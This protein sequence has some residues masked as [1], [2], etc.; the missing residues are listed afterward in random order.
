M[1]KFVKEKSNF[2]KR[3]V[4]TTMFAT[5]LLVAVTMILSSGLTAAVGVGRGGMNVTQQ[6]QGATTP[7]KKVTLQVATPVSVAFNKNMGTSQQSPLGRAEVLLK[8]HHGY[9][10]NAVGFNGAMTWEGAMRLTPVELS[11]YG[12]WNIMSINYYYYDAVSINGKVKIYH[13][14]S[15]TAPGALWESVNFTQSTPGLKTTILPTPIP[16][17]GT[18]DIWVS[19]EWQQLAAGFPFGVDSGPAIDGKGDWI[20]YSGVWSEMQTIPLDFNWVLEALA[21]GALAPNDVGVTSITAPASGTATS[22]IIP[23]ATVKNFGSLNQTNVPV[24]MNITAYGNPISYFSDG[25]ESYTLGSYGFPAGWTNTSINPTGDW[26]MYA[27]AQTYSASTYPRVQEALSDGNAQ[28][29]QLISP[30]IDCSA[31]TAVIKLQFTKYFYASPAA[32]ATFTVYGSDDGGATWAYTLATYTTTSTTA[33]NISIAWAAG[34]NDVRFKFRFQSPADTSLLSYLYFDNLWV[35]QFLGNWGPNGNNPPVGW[36][37][38]R[39]DTT[40]WDYGHWH[41][42]AYT[43]YDCYGS[44]ARM[45]YVSPY[46]EANDNLTSPSIDCSALSRVILQFNGLFYA[47]T[48]YNDK[49]YVQI[50]V[51]GGDWQNIDIYQFVSPGSYGYAYNYEW[52]NGYDITALAAG[53]SNVK[54]RFHFTRPSG[55]TSGYWYVDNVRVG[56]DSGTFKFIE[57]FDTGKCVYYTGFKNFVHDN[58]GGKWDWKPVSM[59]YYNNKWQSVLSGTSPTCTPHGG[60]RMAQ[61]YSYVYQG[62]KAMLYSFPIN[63]AAA[64]M[65]KMSFWMYHDTIVGA[66]KIDVLASH[67]GIHWATLAT[68]NRNDGSANGWYIHIVSLPGYEDDTALQIAFLGT[69]DYVAYMNIDDVNIFDPVLVLESSHT[70]Q[71]N[72]AAGQTVEA[73]FPSWAPA[74]W[75]NLSNGDVTYDVLAAT[76]LSTD[77]VPE[78]DAT[79]KTV[80]LHYPYFHDISVTTISAPSSG[81]AQ[82]LPVKAQIKNIGQYPE[83]LFFVNTKIK[84]IA[85]HNLLNENFESSWGPYGNNPPAGWT[86]TTNEPAPVTWDTNNWYKYAYGGTQGSVARIYYSPIRTQDDSLI[87]PKI[88]CTGQTQI[89]LQFWSYF[90]Y[91][92]TA[93]Y[94]YVDGSINNGTTWPYSIALYHSAQVAGVFSYNISSWAAGQA[95]VKIRFRYVDYDGLYW[96]VDD[97][98]VSA[99]PTTTQEYD[100]DAGVTTWL[101]PGGTRDLTFANWTPANLIAPRISGS[102]DYDITV[103]SQNTPDNNTANN[104]L[105][106]RITLT[107]THDVGI[108]SITSPSSAKRGITFVHYDGANANAVGLTAGGTF[109]AAARFTPT[110]L[111]AYAGY[112]LTTVMYCHGW[113]GGT[114][115]PA[116]NGVLKIYDAGTTTTPGALLYSQAFTSAASNGWANL[117]L[118]TPVTVAGST[119]LWV[120]IEWTHAASQYPAGCDAGPHVPDGDWIYL[121]GSWASLYTASGGAINANWNIR[122]GLE[123]GGGPPGVSLYLQPGV[124]PIKAIA[125]NLGTFVENDLISSAE[126]MNY[127]VNPNGTLDWTATVTG[128]DLNPFVGEEALDFSTFN[129]AD[130]GVYALTVSLPL[131]NDNAPSN[132]VKKLGIGIDETPPVTTISLNPAAPDGKNGWYVHDVTAT[133]TA[134]DPVSH[135]VASGVASIKYKVDG[136]SEMTYTAPFKVTTDKANH[137]ITYWAV[138]KVGN[139][140]ADKIKSFSIDKTPPMI[141]LGKEVKDNKII[142]TAVPLDNLS[143]M[144]YVEFFFNGVL[145]FNATAPGPYTWTLT[146]I[147]HVNGTVKA[148][149][150]DRAGNNASQIRTDPQGQPNGQQSQQQQQQQYAPEQQHYAQ[151]R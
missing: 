80:V 43:S 26:Y 86:I 141:T 67:D 29:E 149:A 41:R 16:I 32:D 19:I 14:G 87:T 52:Y 116:H 114:P 131:G 126:V 40:A 103:N 66:G 93:S 62:Q 28:D 120:S 37:I 104:I 81:I 18:E 20:Y 31:L 13:G 122:A 110:Q 128:I 148:N 58:W 133:L 30:I 2:G 109:E 77:T 100:E 78:N 136:G 71:V 124:Q 65:L 140:E 72:V 11:G 64:N 15:A 118:T 56:D 130:E 57:T 23:K 5:A 8:F 79:L 108:K 121:S 12:G 76:H 74:A 123:P 142:Y 17:S 115:Q 106:K 112:K 102:F 88:D 101:N 44:A 97:V 35:G 46:V 53:H 47:Y 138:D 73:V 1:K 127:T 105:T 89:T 94:G 135:G 95:Q 70:V 61:Y 151:N 10:N 68:F 54:I 50:S 6:T 139:K 49:G 82:M 147:P 90:Y 34:Q 55:A 132:N 59:P 22:Q 75:H 27:S 84:Q 3:L 69:S 45:Y 145:Q 9:N 119:D 33:E 143:G 113:I 4:K 60:L 146:P 111:G 144:W 137:T 91:Y 63:V 83:K 21:T 134:T 24:S 150:V 98:K 107:Y 7:L 92:S 129:F 38:E 42:Y 125:N 25:F 99:P 96:Y 85:Y 48:T 51:D 117:T 36:T 39:K